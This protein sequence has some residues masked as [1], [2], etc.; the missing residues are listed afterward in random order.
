MAAADLTAT[1][2]LHRQH[3]L[4]T[5]DQAVRLGFT[6]RQIDRR[7]ASGQWIRVEAGVFR[8][9]AIPAGWHNRLLAVCLATGGLASHFSAAALWRLDGFGRGRRLHVVVPPGHWSRRPG[10]RLREYTQ[11]ARADATVVDGIPVTGPAVTLLDLAGVVP[12]ERLLVAVDAARRHG[13]VDWPD[14]WRTLLT[15]ARRGRNGSARFRCLLDEHYGARAVPGSAWNRQAAMLVVEAGLPAPQLEYEVLADGIAW[16]LDLA[17][18]DARLGIELQSATWHLDRRSQRRDAHK[19][20]S[21]QQLGWRVYPFTYSEWKDR[22]SALV[23][24]V[25]DALAGVPTDLNP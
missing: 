7:L 15:H 1:P 6:K 10:T 16:R 2:L 17:W 25:A 22:P 5:R 3:G 23:L 12:M 8:H 9:H 14:L 11:F 19:S 4:L 13:L 24:L 20:R 18:P 21:L